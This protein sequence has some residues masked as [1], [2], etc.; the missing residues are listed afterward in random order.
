MR[1]VVLLSVIIPLLFIGLA[2]ISSP[3]FNLFNNAL[4]DLG[5][6]VKSNSAPLFN[7]G[8]ILGGLLAFTVSLRS[9]QVGKAYNVVL[10]YSGLFLILIGAFDEVYGFLHFAVSIMFFIGL[11]SFLTIAVICEKE[12]YIKI[13]SLVLLAASIT[14]WCIH[15]AYR[16]PR[17]AAIPELVSIA[18]FTPIYLWKYFRTKL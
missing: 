14:S 8:L 2:A 17:G 6:A 9:P 3:W 5:H 18:S 1:P 4:S 11:A 16:I 7:L 13:A 10:A 15:Y 12:L